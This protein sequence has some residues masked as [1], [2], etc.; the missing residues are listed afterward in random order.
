MLPV[1]A[2]FNNPHDTGQNLC[3][4]GDS[5]R[6]AGTL[7]HAQSGTSFDS[8]SFGGTKPTSLTH[9][10]LKELFPTKRPPLNSNLSRPLIAN[11]D[12][13][14]KQV[15]LLSKKNQPEKHNRYRAD[16]SS[17]TERRRRRAQSAVENF[18]QHEH[19]C[20]TQLNEYIATSRALS[21]PL[22]PTLPLTH[23]VH[24]PLLGTCHYWLPPGRLLRW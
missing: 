21:A 12:A 4:Q 14:S 5:A 1:A 2:R 15:R 13:T 9:Q 11:G 8:Q 24:S 7:R 10:A 17:D 20:R 18:V 23:I 6:Q 19:T 16:H 22:T 3:T